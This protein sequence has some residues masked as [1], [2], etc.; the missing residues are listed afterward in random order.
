M[1]AWSCPP[2]LSW[3]A[4][5]LSA[6]VLHG[7]AALQNVP[8]VVAAA[9]LD[10]RPGMRV[11]DMCAA[12]GSK[13]AAVADAMQDTGEL[14]ALDK[15]HGKVARII[16]MAAD[17]GL[18]CVTPCRKDST[19]LSP[20]AAST[21]EVCASRCPCPVMRVPLDCLQPSEGSWQPLC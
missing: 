2:G 20:R 15:S 9:V 21:P 4:A 7:Y 10:A 13:T 14:I 8:S 19:K 12:P 6:G 17:M 11:L 18:T 3:Q 5:R 1:S 16:K